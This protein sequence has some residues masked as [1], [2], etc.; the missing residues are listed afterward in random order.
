MKKQV[1]ITGI[2]LVG[3]QVA[4][5]LID[6]FGIK[7]YLLDIRFDKEYLATIFDTGKAEFIQGNI[8]D[9]KLIAEILKKHRIDRVLHLAAVLPMRVGHD[10]HPG[11]YQVNSWGTSNLLF[12]AVDASVERFVMTSTNGVYQFRTHEVTG[13][14]EPDYPT[15]LSEHNSYGNSKAVA[16][17]LLKELVADGKIDAKILRPG[18]IYGPVLN[19]EG[20]EPIYWKAMLDAAIEGKPFLLENHIEHRLDWV[21]AKD[22]AE[23]AVRLLLNDDVRNTAFNASYEKIMGIYD[24][25]KAIDELFPGN[26]IELVNCSKGGWNHPLSMKRVKE[27]L[28]YTPRYDLH[29]G[30]MDYMDWKKKHNL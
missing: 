1:L 16:E 21:Y 25:K 13:P 24:W 6:D 7:P 11:F 23:I 12:C 20:H 10:A 22:V 4:R 17:Y 3:A 15:G 2:G 18:E 9:G 29:Q 30:I 19:R 26:R 14:V 8:L 27:E 5:I 28:D